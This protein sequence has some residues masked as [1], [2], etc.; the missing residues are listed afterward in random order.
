VRNEQ[1][2]RA[3]DLAS[4]AAHSLADSAAEKK[5]SEALDLLRAA[6]LFEEV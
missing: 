6:A 3:L 2:E 5:K 1:G 4:T